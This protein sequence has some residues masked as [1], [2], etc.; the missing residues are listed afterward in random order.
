MRTTQAGREEPSPTGKALECRL[1]KK[2]KKNITPGVELTR[3]G[4]LP[5][6][7]TI[8]RVYMYLV[9]LVHHQKAYCNLLGPTATQRIT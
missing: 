9:A 3:E 2:N 8:T 5:C 1:R 6:G 7:V 4:G